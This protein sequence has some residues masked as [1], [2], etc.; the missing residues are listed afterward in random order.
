VAAEERMDAEA[1]RP[2]LARALAALEDRDRDVLLLYSWADLTYV[3]IAESLEIPLG[4]VRSRL[5]RARRV[6][7]ELL[8]TREQQMSKRPPA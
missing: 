7:R 8:E 6:V 3:E 5:W 4:T 2:L 1:D